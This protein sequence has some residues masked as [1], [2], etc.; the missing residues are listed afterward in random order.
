VPEAEL[1]EIEI[2]FHPAH[3]LQ[4]S[5]RY[6]LA[7]SAWALENTRPEETF[8]APQPS[9]IWLHTGRQVVN[10]TPAL[11]HV[12]PSIWHEPGRFLAERLVEDRPDFVVLA[13]LYYDITRDI[14]WLQQTCGEALEH[15]GATE[16]FGRVVFFRVRY[17]DPCLE[18][19]VLAPT[20]LRLGR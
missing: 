20:R 16:R 15:L 12:G 14:A 4:S 11:P 8:L 10:S 18:D 3:Y 17:D 7:A 19:R 1:A 5:T 2:Q 13:S 6:V 9:G